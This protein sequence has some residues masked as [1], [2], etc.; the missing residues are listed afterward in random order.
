[1]AIELLSKKSG[2]WMGDTPYTVKTIRAPAVLKN[3]LLH[4]KGS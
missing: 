2:E 3:P 4:T 1:M